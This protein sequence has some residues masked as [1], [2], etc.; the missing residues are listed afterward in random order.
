MSCKN[1]DNQKTT[2]EMSAVIKRNS[3]DSGFAWNA[4]AGLVS[5]EIPFARSV[6]FKGSEYVSS[7]TTVNL[8]IN[9][10]KGV[11]TYKIYQGSALQ[12]DSNSVVVTYAG[13]NYSSI[14]GSVEVIQD[15]GSSYIGRFEF[16]AKNLNDT[17][18][19]KNGS[20]NIDK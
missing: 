17:L 16:T 6:R 1:N 19:V 15:N 8:F 20:F 7:P 3:A 11:G 18:T 5:S 9:N 13:R 14:A 4:A 12:T 10:Y 2:R